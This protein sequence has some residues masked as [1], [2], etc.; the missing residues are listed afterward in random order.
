MNH[1]HSDKP[2]TSKQLRL[3]RSLADR[4]GG[5]FAYPQTSA[6]ASEEIRRM[7]GLGTTPPADR[8]RE[9]R[10]VR[11][12]MSRRRESSSVKADELGGYGSTAGWSTAVEDEKEEEEK[13][14]R[15]REA[16]V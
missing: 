12:D 15:E 3:L 14:Q 7:K 6:E 4:T 13:E 5:S 10:A 11:E 2:A 1:N 8:R 9:I 16:V